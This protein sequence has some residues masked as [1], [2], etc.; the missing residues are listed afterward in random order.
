MPIE[1]EVNGRKFIL[2]CD[3]DAPIPDVRAVLDH[4]HKICD[5]VEKQAEEQKKQPEE[6]IEQTHPAVCC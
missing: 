1:A 6:V 5:H 4:F 3:R 2:L